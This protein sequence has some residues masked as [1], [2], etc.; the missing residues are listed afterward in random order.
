MVWDLPAILGTEE[1]ESCGRWV[2]VN[3]VDAA[4]EGFTEVIGEGIGERAESEISV[5]QDS[6]P[7]EAEPALVFQP[8]KDVI[9]LPGV[10][11]VGL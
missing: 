4:V 10:F 6:L 2:F 11:G 8:K 1:K 7:G 3:T 5:A 9:L